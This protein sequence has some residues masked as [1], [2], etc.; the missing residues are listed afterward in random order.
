MTQSKTH[1]SETDFEE[2]DEYDQ[3]PLAEFDYRSIQAVVLEPERKHSM[4]GHTYS[5]YRKYRARTINSDA[6]KK[7]TQITFYCDPFV[8]TLIPTLAR[9]RGISTYT[10]IEDM[11]EE[12]QINFHPDH[13][14]TYEAINN[15]LDDLQSRVSNHAKARALERIVNQKL[16]LGV[17]RKQSKK[18]SPRVPSWLSNDIS[19]VAMDLH[20][21]QSDVAYIYLLT[22]IVFSDTIEIP[23]NS[24][25]DEMLASPLSVFDQELEAMKCTCEYIASSFDSL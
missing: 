20:T 23:L 9:R 6:D 21:T 24:F 14:D 22:G 25:Q 5:E 18:F 10:Y 2:I 15:I 19:S 13:H 8:R 1:I 17:I 4:Y 3:M 16:S 11:L 12:G 7:T